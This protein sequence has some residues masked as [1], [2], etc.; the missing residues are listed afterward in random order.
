M[1]STEEEGAA[2]MELIVKNEQLWD[3]WD[4]YKLLATYL[5]NECMETNLRESDNLRTEVLKGYQ[6]DWDVIFIRST[7]GGSQHQHTRS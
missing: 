3:T 6:P 1:L 4:F 7:N 5:R 2:M